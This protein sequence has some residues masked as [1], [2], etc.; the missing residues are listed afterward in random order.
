MLRCEELKVLALG[1]TCADRCEE[2]KVL[3]LTMSVQMRR[4]EVLV[5]GLCG[6]R[7]ISLGSWTWWS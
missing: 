3:A 5:P 4:L 2:L 1:P 7:L 6:C